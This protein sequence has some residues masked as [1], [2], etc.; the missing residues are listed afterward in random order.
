ML[1]LTFD[2]R[3]AQQQMGSFLSTLQRQ[4]PEVL[5]EIGREI[6]AAAHRDFVVKSRGGTGA[7]GE[8]WPELT[9][10]VQRRKTRRGR[11]SIGIDRG[12]L[13]SLNSIR[14]LVGPGTN[15][16]GKPIGPLE[17]AIDFVDQPKANFFSGHA[18][19]RRP[20]MSAVL[21]DL[22]YQLAT[23]AAQHA[24]LRLTSPV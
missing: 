10:V 15:A 4:F 7:D 3:D 14:P 6:A 20:L 8:K 5:G 22:W 23:R 9:P 21:P 1:S 19:F 12:E 13:G 16:Y 17:V 24:L 11:P 18:G 2:T